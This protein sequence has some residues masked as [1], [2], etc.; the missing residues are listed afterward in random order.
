[1]SNSKQGKNSGFGRVEE[2]SILSWQTECMKT[3]EDTCEPSLKFQLHIMTIQLKWWC[4]F[5]EVN[6]KTSHK[7]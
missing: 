7:K 5:C 1:M 2:V 6:L 3:Y 4:S